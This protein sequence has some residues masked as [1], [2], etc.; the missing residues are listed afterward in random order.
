MEEVRDDH[1]QGQLPAP[2]L[3]GDVEQLL[4]A[5]IPQLALPEPRGP[6]GQHR[7][8]PDGVGVVLQD[9]GRGLAGRHPVVESRCG[10]R[11]PAG[12]VLGELHAPDRRIVPQ[13]SV[14]AAGQVEG[15]RHLGI[16]LNEVEHEP[17]V[18]Q[19]PVRVLPQP[20]DPLP[21]VGAE[22]LVDL[23]QARALPVEDVRTR[24]PEVLTILGQE[25]P[26]VVSAQE[27][28][29]DR[30]LAVPGVQAGLNGEAA[31][32]EADDVPV[33]DGRRTV[34]RLGRGLQRS[35]VR[36]RDGV[37]RAA[38]ADRVAPPLLDAHHLMRV[39]DLEAMINSDV[40]QHMNSFLSCIQMNSINSHEY[41]RTVFDGDFPAT[42][43][44]LGSP[45][46]RPL[47]SPGGSPLR[48]VSAFRTSPRLPSRRRPR[49]SAPRPAGSRRAARPW[50]PS[51]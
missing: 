3:P 12:A 22:P 15:D 2:V 9:L 46:A 47:G 48:A 26:A 36:G 31:D 45:A 38:H 19:P 42:P 7:G 13:E 51:P 5:Q 34:A 4:L 25:L 23:V 27:A 39:P 21:G 8:V 37:R 41:G 43:R 28:E 16:A 6:L 29:H 40:F 11:D 32:D 24:P 17:L 49:T 44:T 20:V 10:V 50:S 30:R 18:I 35:G 1:R 33:P 14:S